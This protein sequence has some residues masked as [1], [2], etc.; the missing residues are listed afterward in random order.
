MG[1][2]ALP[3]FE[4]RSFMHWFTRTVIGLLLLTGAALVE[5]F[6]FWLFIR[7]LMKGGQLW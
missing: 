1:A 6:F 4:R 5:V 3:A 2:E 7:L